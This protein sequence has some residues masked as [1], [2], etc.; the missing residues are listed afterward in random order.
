MMQASKG[1]GLTGSLGGSNVTTMFGARRTSDFLSKATVVLAVIF[2]LTSLLLNIYIGKSG[3]T[4]REG[5]LQKNSSGQQQQ[6]PVTPVN[7]GDQQA[8][9]DNQQQK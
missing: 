7:P 3:N 4:T 8:P 2:M 5:V 1:G 9:V 6:Q